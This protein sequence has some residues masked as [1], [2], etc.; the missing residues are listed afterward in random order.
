VTDVL[1]SVGTMMAPLSMMV[2]GLQLTESKLGKVMLNRRFIAVA[3]IRLAG[4]G[5]ICFL[6]LL[7]F[8]LNGLLS[9]LL[10]GVLTLNVLLPCATV[11]VMFAEEY[12]GNVKT[13]A[14]GT[15]LSTLFSII[16]IPIASVLLGML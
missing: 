8:Y 3:L 16:T 9:P 10:V 6:A 12:G 14:E 4:L 15:F 11:P 1:D 7:P 5:G 2:I 13:A